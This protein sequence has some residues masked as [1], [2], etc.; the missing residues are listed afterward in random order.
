M[1]NGQVM[2]PLVV[3]SDALSITAC[4][5]G[6]KEPGLMVTG[7]QA[8]PSEAQPTKTLHRTLRHPKPRRRQ[9]TREPTA[10]PRNPRRMAP[11][12]L[13]PR[14]ALKQKEDKDRKG[15]QGIGTDRQAAAGVPRMSD[16]SDTDS[17]ETGEGHSRALCAKSKPETVLK[18]K[19]LL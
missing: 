8:H 16:M 4:P 9:R 6:A 1:S 15:K 10:A 19:R 18:T 17:G 7:Q 2:S 13:G 12:V 5:P 3:M 11:E 14:Q